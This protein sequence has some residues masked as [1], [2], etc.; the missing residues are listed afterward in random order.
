MFWARQDLKKSEAFEAFGIVTPMGSGEFD[1]I[2]LGG[3]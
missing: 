2:L 1:D 3:V